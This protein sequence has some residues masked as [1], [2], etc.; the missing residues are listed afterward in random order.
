MFNLSLLIYLSQKEE[1]IVI[2]QGK[3]KKYM[4]MLVVINPFFNTN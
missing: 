4:C 2:M 1:S 3:E